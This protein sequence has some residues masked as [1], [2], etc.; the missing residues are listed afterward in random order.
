MSP[1]ITV[2][3][4][5]VDELGKIAVELLMEQISGE[6]KARDVVLPTNLIIRDSVAMNQEE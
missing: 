5:P 1:S 4:R 6:A 3:S 2:I